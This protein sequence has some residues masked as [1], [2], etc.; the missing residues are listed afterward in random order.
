VTTAGSGAFVTAS[1]Q[2]STASRPCDSLPVKW[3]ADAGEKQ[4][5][6]HCE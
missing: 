1:L 5:T 4:I 2:G 3:A 6:P